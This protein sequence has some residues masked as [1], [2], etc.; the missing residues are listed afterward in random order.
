MATRRLSGSQVSNLSPVTD[1]R[2]ISARE[3]HPGAG[4]QAAAPREAIAMGASQRTRAKPCCGGCGDSPT[5]RMVGAESAVDARGMRHRD[6]RGFRSTIAE[7]ALITRRGR[8]ELVPT[9]LAPFWAGDED[10]GGGIGS[11]SPAPV[12]TVEVHG[13]KRD[14]RIADPSPDGPSAGGGRSGDVPPG[15]GGKEYDDTVDVH[16]FMSR[17]AR[18]DPSRDGQSDPS[19]GRIMAA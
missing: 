1:L 8:A 13:N 19:I 15:P 12:D 7:D 16:G 5:R 4:S 11:G 17:T 18:S 2:S 10:E 6:T 9:L 14:P 3:A